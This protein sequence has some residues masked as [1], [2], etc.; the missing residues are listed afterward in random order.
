MTFLQLRSA[1]RAC[2]TAC[3]GKP[4][5]ACLKGSSLQRAKGYARAEHRLDFSLFRHV[6][7]EG[8]GVAAIALDFVDHLLRSVVAGHV[9]DR[10][11]CAFACQMDRDRAP[12]P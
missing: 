10:H 9:V 5:M 7:L 6:G 8:N 12:D 1:A 2:E 11:R 3:D 4:D